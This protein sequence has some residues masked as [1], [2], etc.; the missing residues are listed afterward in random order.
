M[1]KGSS[2]YFIYIILPHFITHNRSYI[3]LITENLNVLVIL[4]FN[5]NY[6]KI[7]IYIF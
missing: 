7:K 6:I 5:I 3:V 1:K 2:E 4:I